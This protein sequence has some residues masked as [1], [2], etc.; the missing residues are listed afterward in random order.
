MEVV[1]LLQ[2]APPDTGPFTVGQSLAWATDTLARAGT[3]SPRLDAELLLGLSLGWTRERIYANPQDI[4]GPEAKE[5]FRSLLTRRAEGEPC[6]YITGH[7]E[8]WSLD[9][10]V[11]PA[12]LVPR[13]ETER[14]VEIVL[15][16]LDG[17]KEQAGPRILDLGTGSG[18][19]AVALAKERRDLKI[20][21]TDLSAAA[22]AIARAN[23]RRHGVDERVRFIQGDTF[24]P[25]KDFRE[26][27]HGIVSN[28][29]YVKRSEMGALPGEVLR[30]PGLALDGGADGLD[31]Y[32]R[33]VP[34]ALLYLRE[35]GFLALEMAPDMARDLSSLF[36]T[37]DGYLGVSVF[38]DGPGRDRVIC[39]RESCRAA[40][41]GRKG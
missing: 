19:I 20:Y 1:A 36:D 7:R 26:S 11:T 22:L 8:F 12:V 18:A 21:A 27:F 4:L 29:P 41:P 30:E 23:A 14:L 34:G 37:S 33:I 6:A 24:D 25:V 16:Y 5:R 9:F 35:N 2:T 10:L 17:F 32:R 38:R 28:P 3:D 39:A 13:P 15:E 31:L 40:K